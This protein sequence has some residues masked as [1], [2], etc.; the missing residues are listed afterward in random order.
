MPKITYFITVIQQPICQLRALQ[1]RSILSAAN[2]ESDDDYLKGTSRFNANFADKTLTGSL[3]FNEA[4]I[5]VNSRISGNSF[6]GSANSS[7]LIGTGKVEG[8]FYG[9]N[10]KELG[11]MVNTGNQW[12]AAFGAEK[13]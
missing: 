1:G 2:I 6:T 13:K 11:G 4:I 9:N 7:A 3:N 8:K 12:G 5:N 10:A